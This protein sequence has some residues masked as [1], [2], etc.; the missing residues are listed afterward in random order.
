V[1]GAVV[2]HNAK[3]VYRIQED[4][5][6]YETYISF[7]QDCVLPELYKRNHRIFLIQDNASYHKKPETYQWFKQNR[8]RIEVF[9]LPRYQ[10]ELNAIE[11]LW[12]HTRM[13]ATHNRYHET[14]DSL[15][16]SLT[17][18]FNEIQ[19]NPELVKGYL[20]AYS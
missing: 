18:A 5:F 9:C 17:G 3:F 4:Y 20:E 16:E 11:R 10:P 15:R 7:L 2:L 12:H 1:L 8:N 6:N 14:V 19:Q 13:K